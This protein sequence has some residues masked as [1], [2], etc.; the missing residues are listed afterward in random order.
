[1]NK[2][3]IFVI[4]WLTF[5]F[6]LLAQKQREVPVSQ[7]D[8]LSE[9]GNTPEDC[10]EPSTESVPQSAPIPS[11]SVRVP[12]QAGE[13]VI[14]SERELELE[15]R[16]VDLQ[17]LVSRDRMIQLRAQQIDLEEKI[18]KEKRRLQ[19]IGDEDSSV[20]KAR[21]QIE[22]QEKAEKEMR[23]RIAD[24][25]S[26]AKVEGC[27]DPVFS[28]GQPDNLADD[29]M[30]VDI[31]AAS[32]PNSKY[33]MFTGAKYFRQYMQIRI[34]NHVRGP[35]VDIEWND[36][37]FKGVVV[38]NLCPGGR[39]TLMREREPLVDDNMMTVQLQVIRHDGRTMY[40]QQYMMSAWDYQR[41]TFP[42]YQ[43]PVY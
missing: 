40:P 8:C 1:M 21:K 23:Q 17:G 28:F 14:K 27:G 15:Q 2:K 25:R 24:A 36:R 16:L 39:V 10:I 26:M 11:Q 13:P 42:I 37:A 33:R 32:F 12:A 9:P 7:E 6:S 38:K 29:Q 30:W 3:V 22:K 31:R 4:L 18:K 5:S 43:I 34:I 35:A 20:R 41:G 19:K